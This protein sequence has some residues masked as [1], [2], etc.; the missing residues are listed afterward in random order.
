M[1]IM[2]DAVLTMYVVT[3]VSDIARLILESTS[4]A[5][6]L[7]TIK[8]S[9]AHRVTGGNSLSST[10]PTGKQLVSASIATSVKPTKTPCCISGSSAKVGDVLAI[11][12]SKKCENLEDG[13]YV[14]LS[15]F[16][17]VRRKSS[18][19]TSC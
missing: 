8:G 9:C 12:S 2:I 7:R 3:A 6:F 14:S 15:A 13:S 11:G 5:C 19:L 4:A 17:C 16:P 10:K 18:G 1:E